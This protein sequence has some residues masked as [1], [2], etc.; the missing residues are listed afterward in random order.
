MVIT[1]AQ[2]INPENGNIRTGFVEIKA[3]KITRTGDMKD[4]K[5]DVPKSE[6]I[7]ADFKYLTPGL[8]DAHSHIGMWE[9]SLGFE[10]A[11]GLGVFG[12]VFIAGDDGVL[13][14]DGGEEGG[15]QVRVAAVVGHFEYV[16]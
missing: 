15:A 7:N 6:I 1:N 14:G 9:D 8:I 16:A 5:Y 13:R 4:F 10:G 11:D 12:V 3:G 2:I